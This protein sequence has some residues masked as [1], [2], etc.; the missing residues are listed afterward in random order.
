MEARPD[1]VEVHS[2]EM[3]VRIIGCAAG[4]SRQEASALAVDVLRAGR[5]AARQHVPT[6]S[7]RGRLPGQRGTGDAGLASSRRTPPTRSSPMVTPRVTSLSI[8]GNP[9][10]SPTRDR[11]RGTYRAARARGPLSSRTGRRGS[12][13]F[14]RARELREPAGRGLRPDLLAA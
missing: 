11:G 13:P 4:T 3:P 7:Q 5:V 6:R 1:G 9:T 14:F 10:S 2:H 8:N 12:S